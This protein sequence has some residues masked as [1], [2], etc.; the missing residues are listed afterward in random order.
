[1]GFV[2]FK[3]YN[4]VE[5]F[6]AW[7]HTKL[8][9]MVNR[10]MPDVDFLAVAIFDTD[11]EIDMVDPLASAMFIGILG[12]ERKY[13]KL[14]GGRYQLYLRL[15]HF[16]T[17][18]GEVDAERW[19]VGRHKGFLAACVGLENHEGDNWRTVELCVDTLVRILEGVAKGTKP[20]EEWPFAPDDGSSRD[21]EVA[22]T[23]TST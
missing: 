3:G 8:A 22:T 13:T 20:Q 14:Y 23:T 10:Q 11:A 15:R 16:L 21:G 19:G 17:V 12:N 18:G 9:E 4:V 6:G 7:F 2:Y 5:Y 1:M